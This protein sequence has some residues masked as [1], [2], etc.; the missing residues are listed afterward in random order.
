M[1]G[2]KDYSTTQASNTS[3][4]GINTAEGM[5]P[6]D[7][8]NAIRALMKNTREWYNDAQWVIYGDGDAA[9][10]SAYVSASSFTINGVDVTAFYHAGRRV[11]ITGSSTGVVYG[12]IS[13]SSFSTNTTVN[14]TLDSGTLQ[15]ETLTIYLA[16]LT[17]TGNSIP[18]DVISAGNLTNNSITTSKIVD[19]AITNA[20]IADNAVQAAKINSNAV[21]EAKINA[22]AVTATKIGTDAIITSKILDNNVTTSKISDNA[23]T[24]AKINADAINGTKIADDS[25]DSEHLVDG[26]IDSQHIGADQIITSKIA[27]NNITTAKINND[28]VTIGKI[29]D[30]AIVTSSEQS[31][32]TPDNNTFYTTSASDT[33]FLNKD[34][35]ELINSGQTWS[36]SDD[37]IATTAAINARVI[38]LVDDVGGFVPIANETSFPVANPDPSGS[39]GTIVSITDA[40][41]LTYNTGTGQSTNAETT[42]G[43][44]VTITG[45]SASIGSPIASGFGM[46]VETTS[47]LNTYTFTRL[48]PKATEVSTVAANATAIANVNSNS[49]NINSVAGQISPT[50]NLST[51]AGI[52]SAV[53]TVAGANSNI[54]TIASDLGGSN[55]IGTVAGS[56]TNVNNVGGSITNVNQLAG[57][58]SLQTTFIVTV[59]NPGSG[60]VF[61]IDGTNNPTLTLDRGG[62]YIFDQSDN[63][64]S[65]HPLA[66]KDSS[67]AAYTTGVTVTG[68]AGSSG[69]KVTLVVAANAP[70][71]LRY[72]CTYHGNGMGNTISVVNNNLTTVAANI[73]NVNNTGNSITNVNLVGASIANVNNVGTN[74]ADVNSFANQYRVVSSD[75]TSSLDAGDLAYNTSDNNLKY[76]NGSSW[77]S[78]APGI[79]NVVDDSTPQLGGNL[80]LNSNNITGTGGIPA[81]NLTG[82]I[83]EA[84]LPASALGAVWES[85]SIS[86]TAEARKNYFVDTTS[87]TI[88]ATLP[89][90]ASAGDEIRFLDVSG[91]FDT[92]K[93]TINRNSHKIQGVAADLDVE[94]ER[95]G[96]GLVYYNATQGW[97]LKDK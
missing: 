64:N 16:I 55:N 15:N 27:D 13:S 22:G 37:Y 24:T 72:Y 1:A 38:D 21:L 14:V 12:T 3:L 73:T 84:R 71:S 51:V 49:S 7:L 89:S 25:I 36:N 92:N 57:A 82:S 28:A 2:I 17:K 76:Y 4:N 59:V 78:I 50:N 91:T 47:T 69:A 58:L 62:T 43:T 63:T 88:T 32:H 79:A 23:I 95:A 80:D 54:S 29:A 94:T 42:A 93:L 75:P 44:T 60:N 39:T 5:L 41:G 77:T 30:A 18:T 52:S 61:A 11:K 6:S 67:G 65:G 35:S 56:I 74:I 10:T 48:V 20:K 46:L 8:N 87:G 68:T 9:F 53:S 85:K 31:S 90:S 19:D 40:G 97:L 66:F 86:F 70:S 26:S 34:T 96:L 33:R 83:A 81:A 45:I